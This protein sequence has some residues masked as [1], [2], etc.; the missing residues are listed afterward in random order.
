MMDDNKKWYLRF[1]ARNFLEDVSRDA[2]KEVAGLPSLQWSPVQAEDF[3]IVFVFNREVRFSA[4]K[5]F[6]TR[7]NFSAYFSPKGKKVGMA[8]LLCF[9]VQPG[10]AFI[11]G[12]LWMPSSG[13]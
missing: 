2:K 6:L 11:G 10:A 8:W 3:A 4:N 1:P 7:N 5:K 9:I 12:G 13:R